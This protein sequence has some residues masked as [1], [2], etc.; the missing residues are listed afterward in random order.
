MGGSSYAVMCSEHVSCKGVAD[1]LTSR[2]AQSGSSS[3]CIGGNY[4]SALQDF[5]PEPFLSRPR[6]RNKHKEAITMDKYHLE[7]E[8]SY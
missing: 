4:V 8:R 1:C 3:G 2:V 5:C 6:L 7:Y